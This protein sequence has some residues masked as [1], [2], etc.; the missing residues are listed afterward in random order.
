MSTKQYGS[1]VEEKSK[2]GKN[3]SSLN[4]DSSNTT[5][6]SVAE[7]VVGN[8][9]NAILSNNKLYDVIT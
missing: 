5:S 8:V 7:K 2:S 9:E 3:T 4:I 6:S 1:K